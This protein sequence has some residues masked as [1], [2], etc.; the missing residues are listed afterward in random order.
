MGTYTLRVVTDNDAFQE[1]MRE[2]L[3]RILR[4]AVSN[5]ESDISM[6]SILR[7]INGNVVG[8]TYYV[9]NNEG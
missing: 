6:D 4:R 9:E 3:A 8:E 1:D 5:L 2:E 7:D